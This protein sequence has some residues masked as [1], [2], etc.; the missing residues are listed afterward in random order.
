MTLELDNN[1]L[2]QQY[3][4]TP[5]SV[6]TSAGSP[7]LVTLVSNSSSLSATTPPQLKQ[8]IGIIKQFHQNLTI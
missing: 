6:R 7:P 2:L 1:I 4:V 3:R 8:R 5:S